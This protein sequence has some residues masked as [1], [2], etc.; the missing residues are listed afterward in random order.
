MAGRIDL[1]MLGMPD[2]RERTAAEMQAL[3]ESAGLASER[4]VP[5]PTPLSFIEARVR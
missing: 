1:T 2:G 5:T 3:V 4:I